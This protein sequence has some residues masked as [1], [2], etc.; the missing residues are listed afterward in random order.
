MRS[1][2]PR[3]ERIDTNTSVS[4]AS[5]APQDPDCFGI[6]LNASIGSGDSDGADNFQIFVCNR[7]WLACQREAGEERYILLDQPYQTSMVV[8]ALE[9]Y[10]EGCSGDNWPEVVAKVSKIGAGS[11]RTT[12]RS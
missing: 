10:L 5:F 2:K 7:A 9:A 1:V 3:L 12:D 4:F 6:W 11:S 8:E